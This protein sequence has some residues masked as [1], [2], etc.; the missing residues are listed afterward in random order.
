M[1]MLLMYTLIWLMCQYWM[2]NEEMKAKIDFETW[3][4]I[5]SSDGS[6]ALKLCTD[7][8]DDELGAFQTQ[9]ALAWFGKRGFE[10]QLVAAVIFT[11]H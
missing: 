3:K 6:P 2:T 5:C 10:L 11:F 1:S 4:I 8:S 7:C 9:T